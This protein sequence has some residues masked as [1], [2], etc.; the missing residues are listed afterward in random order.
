MIFFPIIYLFS[1]QKKNRAHFQLN[2]CAAIAFNNAT[3]RLNVKPP[4]TLDD[5]PIGKTNITLVTLKLVWQARIAPTVFIA[6]LPICTSGAE[7]ITSDPAS[8][9]ISMPKR[10]TPVFGA[11]PRRS[12]LN[13]F[14]QG[15]IILTVLSFGLLV[16]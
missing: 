2:K 16:S 1:P 8:C 11:S 14:S 4:L 10:Q 6:P 7:R 13:C 3:A 5:H 12:I 15:T 9:L